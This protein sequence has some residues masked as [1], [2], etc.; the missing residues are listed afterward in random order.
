MAPGSIED[1]DENK[2][3]GIAEAIQTILMGE[4]VTISLKDIKVSVKAAGRR[5]RLSEGVIITVEVKTTSAPEAIS[6]SKLV[7]A[8][9]NPA[10]QNAIKTNIATTVGVTIS[11]MTVTT[12]GSGD[13]GGGGSG[14]IIVVA[15]LGVLSLIGVGV[16]C[17]MKGGSVKVGSYTVDLTK[18]S[19]T[20]SSVLS[21]PVS[22]LSAPVPPPAAASPSATPADGGD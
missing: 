22:T 1:Y 2:K 16:F 4:G 18:Y 7:T 6:V 5:R 17:K 9:K 19:S 13:N 15:V 20:L 10:T 21:T 12:T 11:E 3:N 8:L 14:V